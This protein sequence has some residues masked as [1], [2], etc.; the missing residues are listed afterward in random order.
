[1]AIITISRGSYH[2]GKEV[3]EKVAV[4][5]N[6]KCVSREDILATSEQ[7][8][9]PE[10]NLLKNTSDAYSAFGKFIYGKEKFLAFI[11]ASLMDFFRKDNVVYHGF[12]GQV[13]AKKLPFSLNIRV[14]ADIETRIS[15]VMS[16]QGYSRSDAIKF[17]ENIDETRVKWGL[18][19]Y[20]ID[21]RTADIYDLVIHTKKFTVDSA[22]DIIVNAI[23]QPEF[24]TTPE[25]LQIGEDLYLAAK[26]KKILIEK[27]PEVEV[28]SINGVVCIKIA[29]VQKEELQRDIEPLIK[30]I[31]E[32]KEFELYK[33]F[34]TLSSSIKDH[35]SKK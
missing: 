3:A 24:K 23:K 21:I 33:K 32:V 9:L 20:G 31:P 4:R 19:L 18:F 10:F 28:N 22:V 16:S 14:L 25:L 29:D 26:I 17:L 8:K 34:S 12:I 35:I 5:L 1:M 27:Y 15:Y 30:S 2:M 7:F 13:Y 6:Y 11:E